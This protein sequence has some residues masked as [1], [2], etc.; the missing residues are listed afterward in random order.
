MS[1]A[2]APRVLKAP[3]TP[4]PRP[5]GALLEQLRKVPAK[6]TA[7][8]EDAMR[9][10]T[11]RLEDDPFRAFEWAADAMQVAAERDVARR[12]DGE[13]TN[14]LEHEQRPRA[15]LADLRKTIT[16]K[17]V[18]EGRHPTMGSTMHT[19]M[20][21]EATSAWAKALEH[22]DFLDAT[23]LGFWTDDLEPAVLTEEPS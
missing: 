20:A 9:T 17:I 10:F 12:I 7:G 19:A 23:P 8:G 1:T 16:R 6:L 18:R 14:A 21:R 13:I 3:P 11:R 15:I 2:R 4:E 22:L 5:A